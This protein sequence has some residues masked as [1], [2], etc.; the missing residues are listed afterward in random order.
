MYLIRKQLKMFTESQ[1]AKKRGDLGLV[2]NK[3]GTGVS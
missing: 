3:K 2:D 1:Q